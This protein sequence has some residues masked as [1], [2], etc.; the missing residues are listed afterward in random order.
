MISWERPATEN[1]SPHTF[2]YSLVVGFRI[3]P[4]SCEETSNS[5]PLISNEPPN[6]LHDDRQCE[7]EC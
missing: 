7:V 4:C 3:N 6:T 2:G 5:M 1:Q